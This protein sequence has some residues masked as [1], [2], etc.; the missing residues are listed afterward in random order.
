MLLLKAD[1]LLI[2][3]EGVIDFAVNPEMLV[4]VFLVES[5]K[6]SLMMDLATLLAW[7]S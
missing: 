7:I 6:V 1:D 5:R 2:L 4:I 3:A